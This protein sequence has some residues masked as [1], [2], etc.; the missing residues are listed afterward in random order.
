MSLPLNMR[1][2]FLL[3]V[4]L[5]ATASYAIHELLAKSD[6]SESEV[7]RLTNAD[8]HFPIDN[9]PLEEGKHGRVV[10]Y[11]DVLDDV[12]PAVVSV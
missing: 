4:I 9:N 5:A 10:S 7:R 3:L 11:A 2:K 6:A 1:N 12:T 8:E